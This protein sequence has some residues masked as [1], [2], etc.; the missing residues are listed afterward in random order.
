MPWWTC[1]N[2]TN[3]HSDQNNRNDVVELDYSHHSLQDVPSDVFQ[4]EKTLEILYLSANRVSKFPFI[5]VTRS[6]KNK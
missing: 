3:N 5:F 6:T 4:F 2:C 1:F